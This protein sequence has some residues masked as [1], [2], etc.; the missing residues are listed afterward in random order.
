MSHIALDAKTPIILSIVLTHPHFNNL[1]LDA[2]I[3]KWRHGYL[4]VSHLV[5]QLW[6]EQQMEYG[7]SRP[8]EVQKEPKH[9]T[10][11]SE[12]HLAREL[13]SEDYVDVQ[14]TSDED[15]FAIKVRHLFDI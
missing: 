13:Q 5:S 14:V 15:I 9:V 6:C 1:F 11:G 8:H 12:L 10:R 7:F 3:E 4:W 2:P